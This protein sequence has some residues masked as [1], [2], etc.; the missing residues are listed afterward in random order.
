[1]KLNKILELLPDRYQG[2]GKLLYPVFIWQCIKKKEV[3]ILNN[4]PVA[5][6]YIKSLT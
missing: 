4:M 2:I 5:A 6:C 3:E 1:M